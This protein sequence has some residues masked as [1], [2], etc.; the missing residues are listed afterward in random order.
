MQKKKIFFKSSFSKAENDFA[1]TNP[2][3]SSI[4]VN[5]PRNDIGL[6]SILSSI[7]KN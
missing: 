2:Y 1:E 6:S 5:I 3:P 4:S 7:L